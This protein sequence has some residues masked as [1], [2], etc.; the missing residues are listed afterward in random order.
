MDELQKRAVAAVI[1]NVGDENCCEHT[2]DCVLQAHAIAQK[3]DQ[4]STCRLSFGHTH[5]VFW[6]QESGYYSTMGCMSGLP[7]T[8]DRRFGCFPSCIFKGRNDW[9]RVKL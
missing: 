7:S 9:L 8:S 1:D 4:G 2:N 6:S 5:P 3:F